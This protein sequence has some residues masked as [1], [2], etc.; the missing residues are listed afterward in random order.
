M[1]RQKD[2][3]LTEETMQVF[4]RNRLGAM[5][6]HIYTSTPAILPFSLLTGLQRRYI[7]MVKRKRN[8]LG[9]RDMFL[10]EQFR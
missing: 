2:S 7:R 4:V 5:H 3:S 8:T 6:L 1:T 9:D 10:V